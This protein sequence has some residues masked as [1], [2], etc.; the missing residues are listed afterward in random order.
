M[1]RKGWAGYVLSGVLLAMVASGVHAAPVSASRGH[2]VTFS[3]RILPASCDFYLTG[4][5]VYTLRHPSLRRNSGPPV[6][7]QFSGCNAKAGSVLPAYLVVES[8]ST[9]RHA[10]LWGAT[11]ARGTGIALMAAGGRHA[12]ELTPA[13]NTLMLDG[14]SASIFS[15]GQALSPVTLQGYLRTPDDRHPVYVRTAF[16]VSAV[17]G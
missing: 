6:I 17:Y 7:L 15:D 2:A 9:P 16:I 1:N 12:V 3:G 11:R 13:D 10:R 14:P 5:P 8:P 4:G